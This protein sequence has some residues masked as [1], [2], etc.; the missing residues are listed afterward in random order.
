MTPYITKQPAHPE[1]GR[2]HYSADRRRWWDDSE[3][4]WL[5]LDDTAAD[6]AEIQLEESGGESWISSILATLGAQEGHGYYRFVGSPRARTSGGRPTESPATPS[7]LPGIPGGRPCRGAVVSGHDPESA[8]PQRRA[9]ERGLASGRVRGTGRGRPAT[10]GPASPRRTVGRRPR[11]DAAPDAGGQPR[12]ITSIDRSPV[13]STR[14]PDLTA[15]LTTLV[16]PVISALVLTRALVSRPLTALLKWLTTLRRPAAS[17]FS[18]RTE[19]ASGTG[20]NAA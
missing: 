16:R 15:T 6:T 7:P 14:R 17:S 2:G 8:E 18:T 10:A 9:D 11:R 13:R 4:E 20:A 12:P 19:I 5:E 1:R 3:Q